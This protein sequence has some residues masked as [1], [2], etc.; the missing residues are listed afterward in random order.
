MLKL[1][2][3]S[4]YATA[5]ITAMAGEPARTYN[6]AE[7]AARAHVSL[8][9]A[10]K[11]LKLLA[12]AQLVESLRGAHG[13]YKLARG[14]EKISVADIIA[15]VEGPIAV[16]QCAQH[17]GGCS[18]EGS[19]ATRSNWR[20]INGAIRRALEAVTLAQMAA[21]M[22]RNESPIQFHKSAA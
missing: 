5:L 1:S 15:A 2:K 4:D 22:R 16:T 9:T 20:L 7:L 3:L 8:H 18:I 21:P 19:C 13:G 6:A 17:G 14:P 12:K 10:A 11:L